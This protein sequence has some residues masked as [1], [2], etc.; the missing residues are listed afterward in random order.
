MPKAAI[1]ECPGARAM[2]LKEI[3]VYLQHVERA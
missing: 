1:A 3:A 2:S